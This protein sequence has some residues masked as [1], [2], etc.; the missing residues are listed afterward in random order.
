MRPRPYPLAGHVS[1]LLQNVGQQAPPFRAR[2]DFPLL[3]H[4]TLLPLSRFQQ[5][6]R[7][8]GIPSDFAVEAL[9]KTSYRDVHERPAA[10]RHSPSRKDS[11][12][13]RP[14]P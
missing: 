6:R 2:S 13:V 8:T 4:S 14:N 9:R 12:P 1:G 5:R 10:P 7:E 11:R 3:A